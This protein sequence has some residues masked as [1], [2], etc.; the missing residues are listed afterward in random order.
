[1]QIG[2]VRGH[3]VRRRQLVL[4][5]GPRLLDVG[6]G[7]PRRGVL[8]CL[9]LAQHRGERGEGLV[10]PQVVPPLHRD[11]VAEP[12][13]R[14]LVQHRLGASLVAV[15]RDLAPEDVVLQE[16][17]GA[18]V[19]HRTGVELGHEQLVVLAECVWH[20][21]VLV[22]EAEALLGLGEKSVGVHELGERA[23]AE[24]AERD[25]AVFVG[26]HVVP[27]RVRAC[28]ERDQVGAHAGG[29]L[30]GVGAAVGGR[31]GAIGDHLPMRGRGDR[32][33]EGGL[34]VGLVE[35]REHALGIGG[36]ELRVEVDL[37][38]DRIDEPVQTFAG[39]G[40]PAVGVDH[41]DVALRQPGE[42]NAGGLVVTRHVDRHAVQRG[43]ADGLRGDVDDRVRT[44]KRI[45]GHRRRR[46]ERALAWAAGAVGQI[47]DD[48]VVVDGDE[49]RALGCLVASEV[50]K[51]HDGQA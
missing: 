14:H 41:H 17:H 16:C 51:C 46:S 1:M 15:A 27:A 19:L 45:E 21:E 13:V 33:V 10:E 47:E 7:R 34:Q 12:H 35:A 18:C 20:A 40:V 50:G 5:V 9:A 25:L 8:R 3:R 44:G 31:G 30:E 39:V 2:D 22:I 36:F 23:A 29:G 6:E 48:P 37:V 49:R 11:E 4:P 26:V 42:G 32:D 28:D 38:V 43:A 24:D